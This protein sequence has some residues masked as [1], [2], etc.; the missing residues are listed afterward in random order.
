M[1]KTGNL[2]HINIDK[3]IIE[4]IFND[5]NKLHKVKLKLKDEEE[6]VLSVLETAKQ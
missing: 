2:N 4:K 5:K 1:N 3:L 6:L